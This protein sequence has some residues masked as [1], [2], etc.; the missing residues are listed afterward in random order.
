MA[1]SPRTRSERGWHPEP[2]KGH[3]GQ[4]EAGW[5]GWRAIGGLA[6]AWVRRCCDC[7]F[8]GAGMICAW[9]SS[10]CVPRSPQELKAGRLSVLGLAPGGSMD[11]SYAWLQ[12][13]HCDGQSPAPSACFP[14]VLG[15]LPELLKPGVWGPKLSHPWGQVIGKARAGSGALRPSKWLRGLPIG[16]LQVW[17]VA[18]QAV[19]GWPDGV[20]GLGGSCL[21]PRCMWP[22][23]LEHG[24][25]WS[26]VPCRPGAKQ[27]GV[28]ACQFLWSAQLVADGT[29]ILLWLLS[30]LEEM[31]FWVWYL[32]PAS[33]A[34][35]W[36]QGPC[37]RWYQGSP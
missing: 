22:V 21:T 26:G 23:A 2:G 36:G 32:W 16:Q 14:N 12:G 11:V 9:G 25:H 6:R 8:L 30:W 19:G 5:T 17:M 37:R 33:C 7:C 34:T 20:R 4:R 29:T 18:Q 24:K 1:N 27:P 35:H 13:Q 28:G 15:D 10:G 3:T 31:T